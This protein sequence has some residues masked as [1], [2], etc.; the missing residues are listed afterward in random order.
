MVFRKICLFDRFFKNHAPLFQVRGDI[1]RLDEVISSKYWGR[2]A[3]FLYRITHF[4]LPIKLSS[5]NVFAS[6]DA[7]RIDRAYKRSA[8]GRVRPKGLSKIRVCLVIYSI[9]MLFL[10]IFMS[11]FSKTTPLSV[12]LQGI[13]VGTAG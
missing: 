7:R 6:E 11:R 5:S 2:G 8:A 1:P 9:F 4:R 12:S 13:A 10:G 3:W